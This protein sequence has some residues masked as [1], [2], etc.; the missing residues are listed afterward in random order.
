MAVLVAEVLVRVF[1]AASAL[2]LF[3]CILANGLIQAEKDK[4][5]K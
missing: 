3:A 4:R 2:S 1:I 5:S